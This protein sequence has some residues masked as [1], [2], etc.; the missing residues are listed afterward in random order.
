[1][2]IKLKE[3]ESAEPER[4]RKDTGAEIKKLL[5]ELCELMTKLPQ[6]KETTPKQ[7]D[8]ALNSGKKKLAKAI[9]AARGQGCMYLWVDNCCIDKKNNT[10]LVEA[11]SSMG[12]WYKN[13][14]ASSWIRTLFLF[15]CRN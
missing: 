13:A 14:K 11:I 8:D 4:G 12:D 9:A 3:K 15:W 7:T 10:E 1:M 2:I 5:D 6:K